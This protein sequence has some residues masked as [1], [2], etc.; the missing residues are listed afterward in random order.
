MDDGRPNPEEFLERIR[1]EEEIEDKQ[2]R[3]KLKIFLGYAAGTGKTYA[4]LEMAHMLQREDIDVVA[5]YIEPHERPETVKM[6]EGIEQLPFK[7]VEYKGRKFNE[8][9]IDAALIRH[10][11]VILV[12]ELA[13]TNAPGCRHSKRYQ[14][15]EELLEHG[16]N[17]YTT[18]N[19]QHL[20]SLNDVVENITG[21]DMKERIPDSIFDE[22]DQVKMVDIEPDE[23]IERMKEGK[24]YKERQANQALDNFFKRNKLIALR[25]MSLRRMADRVNHIA[26]KENKAYGES[27]VSPEEH[28]LVCI[29]PSPSNPKCIRKAARL[30]NALHAEF[31][32]IYVETVVFQKMN[33]KFKKQRDENIKLARKLGAKVVTV[34]S[35][36][37]ARQI[38]EY[39]KVSHV[40]K[41]VIGKRGSKALFRR[42]KGS[43]EEEIFRYAPAIDIMVAA[44]EYS[45][46]KYGKKFYYT[47]AEYF[48]NIKVIDLLKMLSILIISTAAGLCF[49]HF[50]FSEANII[51]I[52]LLGI[53]A[54]SIYTKGYF[55]SSLLSVL[56]VL[57]FNYFFI[58]PTHS[59]YAYNHNYMVTF[60]M[61]FV[62]GIVSSWT[63][64]KVQKQNEVNAKRAYRTEILLDNSRRLRRTFSREGVGIE[65]ASQIQ[66]L[67]N[68]SIIFYTK[69]DGNIQEPYI[70]FRKNLDSCIYDE[71]KEKYTD[72][73]EQ[74]VVSWVFE[75]GHRAGCT[76]STLSDA[77]A[78]YIPAID[79][80]KVTAVVGLVLEERREIG[81][82]K[83]DIISAIISEAAFVLERIE[84]MESAGH[85]NKQIKKT[86]I[87]E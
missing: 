50:G 32:A 58:N 13:H 78:I 87:M 39:A 26:E 33:Y 48:K 11:K 46:I 49:Q 21:I 53:M 15:I 37:A 29:S 1:V 63:M 86:K 42:S 17:V 6:M 68:L 57:S 30:A 22:A 54:T 55:Y 84:R 75:N 74:S 24:I 14:D 79:S 28:I 71:L 51:M 27:N 64:S 40:S 76:T 82:F 56:G 19:I 12:D 36:N 59:L 5:G 23:L 66:K 77:Q 8:F 41:I 72:S 10:P 7:T 2:F 67:V 70:F 81:G 80:E 69:V 9:D 20:E 35:N 3:G 65:L 44:D 31:T 85:G 45:G 38:A 43:F 25:E 47:G 52:Y 34:F 60:A 61:M 16:I 73:R 18:V 62:V 83:Y 4:M